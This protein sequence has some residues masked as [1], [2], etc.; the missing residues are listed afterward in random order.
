MWA[1]PKL[2]ADVLETPEVLGVEYFGPDGVAIRVLGKTRPGSQF[3]VGR[4]LRERIAAA[5][6]E[7]GIEGPPGLWTRAGTPPGK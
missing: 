7:A 1:D 2:A 5:L 4:S 6:K 3:T